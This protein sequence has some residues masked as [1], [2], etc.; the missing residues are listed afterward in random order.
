VVAVSPITV[1][2]LQEHTEVSEEIIEVFVDTRWDREE[3][4]AD[5]LQHFNE[6]VGK[7]QEKELWIFS[8]SIDRFDRDV[9][10]E[11]IVDYYNRED[12]YQAVRK[13][14]VNEFLSLLNDEMFDDVN[15]WE[16]AIELPKEV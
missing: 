1:A 3:L 15:N 10:D 2:Y 14:T 13:M 12:N 11:H 4:F 6:C 8:Y 5:N 16:R 9:L 7:E